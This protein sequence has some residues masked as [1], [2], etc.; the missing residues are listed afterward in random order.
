MQ[1]PW[2]Y[3]GFVPYPAMGE[4]YHIGAVWVLSTLFTSMFVFGCILAKLIASIMNTTYD[5]VVQDQMQSRS[6]LGRHLAESLF[7]DYDWNFGEKEAK[8][9]V[10]QTIMTLNTMLSGEYANVGTALMYKDIIVEPPVGGHED[11]VSWVQSDA[12][13]NADVE[14]RANNIKLKKA[15]EDASNLHFQYFSREA[16]RR[17]QDSD[18]LKHATKPALAVAVMVAEGQPDKYQTRNLYKDD[19]VKEA[20]ERFMKMKELYEHQKEIHEQHKQSQSDRDS[21]DHEDAEQVESL[22]SEASKV[23]AMYEE[24]KAN[25]DQAAN[26][27]TSIEELVAGSEFILDQ[28]KENNSGILLQAAQYGGIELRLVPCVVNQE[29]KIVCVEPAAFGSTDKGFRRM[30]DS[31]VDTLFPKLLVERDENATATKHMMTVIMSQKDHY[32]TSHSYIE[33]SY[34]TI[35]K[36]SKEA[37]TT[38]VGRTD[39][40]WAM[41]DEDFPGRVVWEKT[42]EGEETPRFVKD[43]VDDGFTTA[44]T[45][46]TQKWLKQRAKSRPYHNFTTSFRLRDPNDTSTRFVPRYIHT[47]SV[48]GDQDTDKSTCD[49]ICVARFLSLLTTILLIVTTAFLYGITLTNSTE[50]VAFFADYVPA[51]ADS[52]PNLILTVVKT[53]VPV[54]VALLVDLEAYS[55]IEK[56]LQEKLLRVYVIKMMAL[57][58]FA[59]Q[60]KETFSQTS[61]INTLTKDLGYATCGAHQIGATYLNLVIVNTVVAMAVN[62]VTYGGMYC[63]TKK[64]IPYDHNVVALAYIELFYNQGLIWLGTP[65]SP[66]IPAVGCVL[67]AADAKWLSYL[68]EKFCTAADKTYDGA[69]AK[70]VTEYCLAITFMITLAPVMMFLNSDPMLGVECETYAS[71]ANVTCTKYYACGPINNDHSHRYQALTDYVDNDILGKIPFLADVAHYALEPMVAY[72]A[73]CLVIA[74]CCLQQCVLKQVRMEAANTYDELADALEDKALLASSGRDAFNRKH[75]Q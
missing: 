54:V 31:L 73:L 62:T 44:L 53:L 38:K 13:D 59:Y 4:D 17:G 67:A 5:P 46:D 56:A 25:M 26:E 51:F 39:G 23:E 63:F 58:Y 37:P 1:S 61:T 14:E 12:E 24:A 19:R 72:A 16:Y 48:D 42:Q 3:T 32:T 29:N 10:S 7:T 34:G 6:K 50:I 9:A 36:N 15:A 70:T 33:G 71:A 55:N 68:M 11:W 43:L 30:N 45:N 69:S 64:L 28:S 47:S 8:I 2:Y 41:E 52:A 75:D 60:L 40:E 27:L 65:Y 18:E 35:G 49:V 57:L 74:Y 21:E 22:L 66:F 20:T